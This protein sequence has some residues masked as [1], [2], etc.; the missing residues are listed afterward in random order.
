MLR[1]HRYFDHFLHS[2]PRVRILLRIITITIHSRLM[3]LNALRCRSKKTLTSRCTRSSS[4]LNTVGL[5]QCLLYKWPMTALRASWTVDF[6]WRSL[7]WLQVTWRLLR[8]GCTVYSAKW[9]L[10]KLVKSQCQYFQLLT[11]FCSHWV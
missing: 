1:S 4:I 11:R 6:Q 8:A 3:V 5:Q 2:F 9:N 10:I 7:K